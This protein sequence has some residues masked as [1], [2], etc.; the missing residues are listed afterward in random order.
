MVNSSEQKKGEICRKKG[1]VHLRG[2][3]FECD[4]G[5]FWRTKE[6]TLWWV[7]LRS[8]TKPEAKAKCNRREKRTQMGSREQI[9]AMKWAEVGGNEW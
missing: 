3:T 8:R 2:E 7:V 5:Q 1:L 9:K 6:K 4:T